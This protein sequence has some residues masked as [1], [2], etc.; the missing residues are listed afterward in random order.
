MNTAEAVTELANSAKLL[1]AQEDVGLDTAEILQA[2]FNSW[3]KKL[4]TVRATGQ[5]Q[6]VLTNA[7]STGPWSCEQTENARYAREGP[8][9]L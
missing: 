9:R 5:E 4:A 1:R 7:I 2:M 8:Q 6:V 3:H